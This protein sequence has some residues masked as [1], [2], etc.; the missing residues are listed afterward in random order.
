MG[1]ATTGTSSASRVRQTPADAGGLRALKEVAVAVVEQFP[2]QAEQERGGFAGGLARRRQGVPASSAASTWTEKRRPA[3]SPIFAQA[4]MTLAVCA[5][6]IA[7]SCRSWPHFTRLLFDLTGAVSEVV[8]GPDGVLL[9]IPAQFPRLDGADG[10]DETPAL[11]AGDFTLARRGRFIDEPGAGR[12]AAH[13]VLLVELQ[14]GEF[15][16]EFLQRLGLRLWQDGALPP[17]A[18]CPSPRGSHSSP[19]RH[20]PPRCSR[21][22]R[23]APHRRSPRAR[24]AWCRRARA[25]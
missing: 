12:G 24:R 15:E 1:V 14:V 16:D 3:W 23:A 8:A 22:C 5:T 2:R 6:G 11:R 20:R 9:Q 10:R 21:G 17:G 19:L 13:A 7:A 18:A 4:L 25:E